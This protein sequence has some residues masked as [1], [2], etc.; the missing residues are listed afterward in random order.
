[1]EMPCEEFELHYCKLLRFLTLEQQRHII[2]QFCI[3]EPAKSLFEFN[4]H[5]QLVFVDKFNYQKLLT[6][7]A[8]GNNTSNKK[9]I[10][11]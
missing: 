10:I 2:Y 9:D 3:R 4:S 6:E 7:E 5:G 8:S 11:E 1:M